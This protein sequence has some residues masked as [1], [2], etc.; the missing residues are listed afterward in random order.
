MNIQHSYSMNTP[1]KPGIVSLL[2]GW[3]FLLFGL[4]G[5][6]SVVTKDM[7][8]AVFGHKAS[9][10]VE[11][12]TERHSSSSRIS[13]DGKT[14]T[15]TS[16]VSRMMHLRFQT[17][18]GKPANFETTSTFNTEA[19]V[20]D[21]HP[22]LYLPGDTTRAEINTLRQLWLPMFVGTSVSCVCLGIGYLVLRW[23]SLSL[24]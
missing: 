11:K 9:A 18:D 1:S 12:V 4:L 8:V 15:N 7:R 24:S 17:T 20:G 5:M 2:L 21:T 14:R 3:A 13:G 10:T 6:F 22:I 23:R 16:S 19:K